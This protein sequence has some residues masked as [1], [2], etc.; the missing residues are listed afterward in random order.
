MQ[1]ST[2]YCSAYSAGRA[3]QIDTSVQLTKCVL[4][5]DGKEEASTEFPFMEAAQL[6]ELSWRTSNA[7]TLHQAFTRAKNL[8]LLD[9][10]LD[11]MGIS[12]GAQA[13]ARTLAT[14][15]IL[16]SLKLAECQFE[17]NSPAPVYTLQP[18]RELTR[19]SLSLKRSSLVLQTAF[20]SEFDLI[21]RSC[22]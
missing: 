9:L 10:Q 11:S 7:V 21:W 8:T 4:Q 12:V 15:P 6:R 22:T 20:L 3:V 19:S 13:L 16:R 2:T 1:Y 17:R 18:L 14:F 5:T